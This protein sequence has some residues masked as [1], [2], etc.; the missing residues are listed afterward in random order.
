MMKATTDSLKNDNM[1]T[2]V[3]QLTA[4]LAPISLAEMKHVA[5][6]KRTDTKYVMS[7]Q[8]LYQALS[9]LS[10]LYRILDID[11]R[12]L[13]QSPGAEAPRFICLRPVWK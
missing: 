11:R 10:D 8:Q 1:V 9:H 4:R 3:R 7:R 6:L 13:H 2:A 5:L 12:R